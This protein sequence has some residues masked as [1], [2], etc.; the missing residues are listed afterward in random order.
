MEHPDDEGVH[1]GHVTN[2]DLIDVTGIM[3][4]W[5]PYIATSNIFFFEDLDDSDDEG[6]NEN[7]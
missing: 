1:E 7:S 5:T 3:S 4:P 6:H 2:P